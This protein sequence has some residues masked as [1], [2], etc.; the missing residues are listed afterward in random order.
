MHLNGYS[1]SEIAEKTG[2]S[3]TTQSRIRNSRDSDGFKTPEK[4]TNECGGKP[5]IGIHT[6]RKILKLA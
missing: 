6:G 3:I 2:I 1:T 5:V 4:R